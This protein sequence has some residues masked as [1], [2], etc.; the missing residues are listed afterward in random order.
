MKY[1]SMIGRSNLLRLATGVA[2]A[3]SACPAVAQSPQDGGGLRTADV[4][5]VQAYVVGGA[6]MPFSTSSSVTGS[7][8]LAGVSTQ[9]GGSSAT[10]P[11]LGARVLV[12]FLWYMHDDQHL[13]FSA[14]FETGLQSG[15]GAQSRLQTFQNTSPT[16][17]DF[18]SSA[19]REYYQV[20]VLLGL[21]VPI[22]HGPKAPSA[23]LDFY[24]GL[25]LDSWSQVLQGS[26][27]NA[28]GTPGFYAENRHVTFDPTVGVGLRLPV[29][30]LEDGL[31][32]F[33]GAN[34]ELQ[35]RPGNTVTAYSP[36]F[37]VT[38]S[39]AVNPYANL[40][41]MA[42]VGIAFGSR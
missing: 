26:E 12:P 36:N 4:L 31:P 5:A 2:A 23:L 14:F 18:G 21:T 25:T 20:P 16:A 29:G 33:V 35:F 3:L 27:A 17:G 42:R 7:D 8:A 37:T 32:I 41:L 1:L 13:G 19:I 40:A 22:A 38:Y 39:S 34:A 28:P 10:T 11:F 24:G 9:L 6:L 15:F 30:S